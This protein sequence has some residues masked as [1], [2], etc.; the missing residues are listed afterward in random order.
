MDFAYD[1]TRE[2]EP[3]SRVFK[4]LGHP[5]RVYL[6]KKI[7]DEPV[8]VSELQAGSNRSQS[9]ISQHLGVLRNAGLIVPERRGNLTCYRAADHRVAELLRL[10]DE[11]V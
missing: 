6:L 10:A 3:L 7:I 4:A 1:N 5:T 8:C 9:N 11:M 2:F